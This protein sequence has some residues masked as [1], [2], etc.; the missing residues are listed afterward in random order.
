MGHEEGRHG[1]WAQEEDIRTNFLAAGLLE[2]WRVVLVVGGL[3]EGG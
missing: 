2:V 3:Q 1:N